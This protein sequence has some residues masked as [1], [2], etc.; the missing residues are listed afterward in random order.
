MQLQALAANQHRS[1]S[2]ILNAQ[3]FFIKKMLD[4]VKAQNQIMNESVKNN[5]Q[6]FEEDV[7]T[8]INQKV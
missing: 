6:N 3:V 7:G 4:T 1:S 5:T 8:K 2:P